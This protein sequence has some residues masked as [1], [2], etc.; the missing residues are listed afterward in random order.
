MWNNHEYFG[1]HP[2]DDLPTGRVTK[3]VEKTAFIWAFL[4]EAKINQAQ[5]QK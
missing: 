2:G 4:Q 1:K 3:S 5:R